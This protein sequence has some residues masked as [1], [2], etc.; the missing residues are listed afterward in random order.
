MTVTVTDPD[1]FGFGITLCHNPRKYNYY[2]LQ[3]QPDETGCVVHFL[4]QGEGGIGVVP[5]IDSYRFHR[6]EDG[7]YDVD[8]FTDGTV[9]TL[10]INEDLCY[11][12][13]VYAMANYNWGLECY[14][15]SINVTDIEH[16]VVA[17][18]TAVEN[19]T[20]APTATKRIINGQLIIIKNGVRYNAVGAKL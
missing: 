20:E 17:A 19:V 4:Q 3:V 9:L 5:Y 1:N 14:Q 8:V 12:N 15:G 11:T 18:P 6:A 7:I 16:H 13:R 10:Y 2:A